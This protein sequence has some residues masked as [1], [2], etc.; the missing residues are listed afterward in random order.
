[1]ASQVFPL[2]LIDQCIGSE[3]WVL[4]RDEKEFKGTLVGFDDF[5]NIVLENATE[6]SG[7][8]DAG[9]PVSKLLLNGNNIV[10]LIPGGTR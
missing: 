5:V 3:M 6:Y 9:T 8:D 4:M 10:M 7:P 2:E 1:M